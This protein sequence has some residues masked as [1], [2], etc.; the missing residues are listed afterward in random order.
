MTRE[1]AVKFLITKPYKLGHLLGFEKL[2][3][4]HN[5]WIAEMIK[6]KTDKTLQASRG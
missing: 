6:G 3:P 4:I 5:R 1:Q 2:L